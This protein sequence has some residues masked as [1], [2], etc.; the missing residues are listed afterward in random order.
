M[1]YKYLFID[2]NVGGEVHVKDSFLDER[3]IFENVL[4]REF[5]DGLDLGDGFDKSLPFDIEGF[6]GE[7]EDV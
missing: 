4:S 5:I 6:E 7:R 3:L 2:A 1:V